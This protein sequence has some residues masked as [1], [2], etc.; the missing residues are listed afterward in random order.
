MAKSCHAQYDLK[1]SYKIDGNELAFETFYSSSLD[2]Y[3][4][5][6]NSQAIGVQKKFWSHDHAVAA[7]NLATNRVESIRVTFTQY[8]K[9]K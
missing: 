7:S 9:L 6:K 5:K 1:H 4:C 8:R 3:T 2:Y